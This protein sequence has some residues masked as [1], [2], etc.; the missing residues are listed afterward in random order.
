MKDNIRFFVAILCAVPAI[1]IGVVFIVA[2]EMVSRLS[3]T[4]EKR[5]K[6]NLF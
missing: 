3:G 6:L 1:I 4:D 5:D 2:R